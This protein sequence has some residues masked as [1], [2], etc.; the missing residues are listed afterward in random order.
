MANRGDTLVTKKG[1]M[2]LNLLVAI[3]LLGSVST[4]SGEEYDG[5]TSVKSAKL[6]FDE[7]ESN[8]KAAALH[9][10]GVRQT[11]KD[12]AA[13]KKEPA[14]VIVFTG[15]S[16]KLISKYREGFSPVGAQGGLRKLSPECRDS[17]T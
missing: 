17:V 3:L 8:P 6:P 4:A 10:K 11:Y 7:R 16:V 1:M 2:M 9:L 5:I 14:F 13:I 15:P 12:R